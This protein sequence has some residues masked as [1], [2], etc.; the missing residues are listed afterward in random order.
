MFSLFPGFGDISDVSIKDSMI[1]WSVSDSLRDCV[2]NYLYTLDLTNQSNLLNST[3][4]R[5]SLTD[6]GPARGD[7]NVDDITIIP[8]I[9]AMD[10]PLYNNSA[11]DRV[12]LGKV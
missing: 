5:M 2:V 4:N 3:S 10:E 6:F 8:I 12:F 9:P 1:E 7:C 11:T